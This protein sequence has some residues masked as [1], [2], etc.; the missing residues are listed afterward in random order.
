MEPRLQANAS[1]FDNAIAKQRERAHQLE[2]GIEEPE[3][4]VTLDGDHL[5][6]QITNALTGETTRLSRR[7]R[8]F[9]RPRAT[10]YPVN[11]QVLMTMERD[12]QVMA[13]L[14]ATKRREWEE[15]LGL[16]R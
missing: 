6:A 1:W 5:P 12:V 10:L 15:M 8:G 16:R 14:A 3:T 2:A 9:R 13:D 11:A 7:Q 4:P